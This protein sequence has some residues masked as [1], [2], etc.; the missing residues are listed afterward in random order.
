M[1]V[2]TQVLYTE[3][4]IGKDLKR[5]WVTVGNF[6]VLLGVALLKADAGTAQ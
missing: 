2:V 4:S 3:S 5:G 6:A 1:L